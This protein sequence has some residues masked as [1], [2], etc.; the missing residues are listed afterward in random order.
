MTDE[1]LTWIQ[2]EQD[3]RTR[4]GLAYEPPTFDPYLAGLRVRVETDRLQCEGHML[5]SETQTGSRPISPASWRIGGAGPA[6]ARWDALELGMSSD[7]THGGRMV[8]SS[9]DYEPDAWELRIPV[10]ITRRDAHF[11]AQAVARQLQSA[12]DADDD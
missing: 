1:A 4:V 10:L 12:R 5:V 2:S 3:E 7:A 8:G 11:F 6:S 9:R